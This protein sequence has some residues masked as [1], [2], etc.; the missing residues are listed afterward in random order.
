MAGMKKST[1]SSAKSP[2]QP[3]APVTAS[4]AAV[5]TL[6]GKVD[7]AGY[8]L[9]RL[10]EAK[11]W[12][13]ELESLKKELQEAVDDKPADKPVRLQ[14]GVYYVDLSPRESKR[15]ITNKSKAW[16]ALKRAIGLEALIASLA[17]PFKLLDQHIQ[18]EDQAAYTQVERTGSRDVSA[19]LLATVEVAP[20]A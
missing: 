12:I 4:P 18:P 7:R 10:A 8:L 2:S 11:P 15:E 20:Q 13:K 14:G 9:A 17:I 19:G 5:V 3:T 1:A 6:S 16:A